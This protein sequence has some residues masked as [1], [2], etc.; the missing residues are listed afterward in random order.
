LLELRFGDGLPIREI[1]ARWETD[2]AALHREYA[3]AR[4]EFEDALRDVIRDE[5]GGGPESV[6]KECERLTSIFR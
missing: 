4:R 6:Q 2:A 5:E 1:A 3:K